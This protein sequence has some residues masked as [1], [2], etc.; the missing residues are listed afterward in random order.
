MNWVQALAQE[1][2]PEGERQ[3]VKLGEHSILLIHHEGQIY[4]MSSACPHLHLPLKGAKIEGDTITC[5]W[6]H[7]AFDLRTGDV[8]A[9]SPWPPAVGPMLSTLSRKKALHLYPTKV[10]AGSIWVGIEDE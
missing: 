4:A 5:R 1:E 3:V 7:S 10:E 9:W 2:L 6:H 8:K